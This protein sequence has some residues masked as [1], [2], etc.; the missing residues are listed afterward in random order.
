MLIL[1]DLHKILSKFEKFLDFILI[2]LKR[3][4]GF[5]DPLFGVKV[6]KISRIILTLIQ[7]NL[8]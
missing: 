5:C 7:G 6:N 3:I 1:H 4:E 2:I 8:T